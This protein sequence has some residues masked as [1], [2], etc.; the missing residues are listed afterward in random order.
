MLPAGQVY[1]AHHD[2]NLVGVAAWMPLGGT[3]ADAAA[4][5]AAARQQR[6]VRMMFPRASQGLFGGFA[7]IE[8][9]HPGEPQVLKIADETSTLSD[10][11][12]PFPRTRGATFQARWNKALPQRSGRPESA[13]LLGLLGPMCTNGV[14]SLWRR[15]AKIRSDH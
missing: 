13:Y 8:Q 11:E 4:Q 12:T 3:A 14:G 1:A 9:F 10:L 15:K 5:A 6:L 7:A 2:G